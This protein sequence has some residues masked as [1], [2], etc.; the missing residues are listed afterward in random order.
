MDSGDWARDY[1]CWRYIEAA[2]LDVFYEN[3]RRDTAAGIKSRADTW[4]IHSRYRTDIFQRARTA[5]MERTE[6]R[7]IDFPYNEDFVVQ[8]YFKFRKRDKDELREHYRQIQGQD[9]LS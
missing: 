2:V 4:G 7:D 5:W 3:E 6:K 9:G 8:L 1:L